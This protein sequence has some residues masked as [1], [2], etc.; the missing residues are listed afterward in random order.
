MSISCN[1]FQFACEPTAVL[2]HRGRLRVLVD[3]LPFLADHV[4]FVLGFATVVV[5]AFSSFRTEARAESFL[6][7]VAHAHRLPQ[8]PSVVTLLE[9]DHKVLAG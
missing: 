9:R 6:G 1:C 3:L 7:A 8:K 4:F 5:L 2:K